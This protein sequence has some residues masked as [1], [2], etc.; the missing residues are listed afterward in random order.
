[1]QFVGIPIEYIDIPPRG[2]G[3]NIK[4]DGQRRRR[5]RRDRRR[6]SLLDSFARRAPLCKILRWRK[7]RGLLLEEE[8][9]A[10]GRIF[11]ASEKR[12][13]A[14]A[15]NNNI[16]WRE[17]ESRASAAVFL[18]PRRAFVLLLQHMR[19]DVYF[20]PIK[21]MMSAIYIISKEL[22]K[23]AFFV[24]NHARWWRNINVESRVVLV[25][26]MLM[27][28]AY[29]AELWP[30]KVQFEEARWTSLI[31]AL[32]FNGPRARA[33]ERDSLSGGEKNKRAFIF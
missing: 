24:P 16:Q 13:R 18:F 26:L 19:K 10:R 21:R 23:E 32:N 27:Q 22:W 29:L 30:L 11:V 9:R 1:M 15:R 2:A 20:L 25:P 7:T 14:R 3:Q 31:T 6:I 5:R 12:N 4:S 33:R 17:S 8:M 28:S